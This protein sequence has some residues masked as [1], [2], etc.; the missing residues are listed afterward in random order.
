VLSTWVDGP[1]ADD[2]LVTAD[3][4]AWRKDV[5]ARGSH[6]F[7]GALAGPEAATTVRAPAG[8]PEL[9]DGPFLRL[10]AF[11]GGVDVIRCAD[12]QQAVELAAAHPAAQRHA[13]EVRPFHPE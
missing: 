8:E 4:D 1:S 3:W 10:E 2:Q 11:I 6:M 5:D 7:G 13:V 9:S 12:R